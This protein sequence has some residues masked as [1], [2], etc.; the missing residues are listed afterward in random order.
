MLLLINSLLYI[1]AL[2]LA[3]TAMSP[4]GAEAPRRARIARATLTCAGGAA[5]T[6]AIT[7]GF[8]GMWFESALAGTTAIIV[9]G[10]CMCVGLAREAG[11]TEDEDEDDDDG[12]SLYRPVPP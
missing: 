1:F 3:V 8:V 2:T 6:A 10:A 4:M 12:G 11:Q 5:V 9:V 7:L